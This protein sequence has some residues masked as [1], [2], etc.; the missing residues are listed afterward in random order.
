[1]GFY[2]ASRSRFCL[3]FVVQIAEGGKSMATDS[4]LDHAR[5]PL[6]LGTVILAAGSSK[7]MGT[8]KMLLPWGGT[9]VLGHIIR[10]WQGLHA[11]QVTVVISSAGLSLSH[12]LDL[13]GFPQESRIQNPVP[14]RGMFSSIQCAASWSGWSESL[15]HW[16]LLLGDQPHLQPATLRQLLDFATQHPSRVC[17][18]MRR[19]QWRHPVV[20][21]RAVFSQ[22]SLSKVETLRE[23]LLG[24]ERA[25]FECEDSGLDD[26]IDTPEDY[27]KALARATL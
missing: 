14:E 5:G 19:S 23:F 18:P 20:L 11:E 26:D 7:R 17:Q 21:P 27:R 10:Q 25:G 15:T 9:S 3:S 13:L 8:P 6:L 2:P 16:V 12:E 22:L 4:P 24:F 1:M